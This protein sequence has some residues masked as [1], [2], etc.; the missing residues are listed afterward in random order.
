MVDVRRVK[1]GYIGLRGQILRKVT[2]KINVKGEMRLKAVPANG[3]CE[4]VIEKMNCASRTANGFRGSE[5][6]SGKEIT[7]LNE[8]T[9]DEIQ[10]F[11]KNE[12]RQQNNVWPQD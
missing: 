10:R 2:N 12:C 3:N 1:E 4:E 5:N 6:L 7:T 9:S 8:L 11:V